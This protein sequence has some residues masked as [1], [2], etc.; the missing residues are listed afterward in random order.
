MAL[1]VFAVV[2][3]IIYASLKWN[4]II[5][6]FLYKKSTHDP[7]LWLFTVYSITCAFASLLFNAPELSPHYPYLLLLLGICTVST[8]DVSNA[9]APTALATCYASLPFLSGTTTYKVIGAITLV[10]T[11]GTAWVHGK[12]HKT[13]F[14]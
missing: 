14:V 13:A 3:S 12:R 8:P 10:L 5:P 11:I 4:W 7:V 6:R 2:F 9:W 1:G